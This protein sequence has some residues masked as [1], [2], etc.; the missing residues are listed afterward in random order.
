MIDNG[1]IIFAD[2]RLYELASPSRHISISIQ[3]NS[4]ANKYNIIPY[5]NSYH[6]IVGLA[7]PKGV[8][9]FSV[10]KLKDKKYAERV[11]VLLSAYSKTPTI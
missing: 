8:V 7:V 10:D 6:G 4:I 1:T 5:I 9:V 2:R 11:R 3:W